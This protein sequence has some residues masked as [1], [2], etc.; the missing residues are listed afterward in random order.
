MMDQYKAKSIGAKLLDW[1]LLKVSALVAVA[2]V[3]LVNSFSFEIGKMTIL[4]F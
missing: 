1:Q 4:T 3:W 2:V